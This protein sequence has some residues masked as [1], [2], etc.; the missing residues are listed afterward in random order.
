V[1]FAGLTW[2]HI[3]I[4]SCK[5]P[6][7]YKQPPLQLHSNVLDSN[8]QNTPDNHSQQNNLIVECLITGKHNPQF[9]QKLCRSGCAMFLSQQR[10][11][12]YQI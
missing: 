12:V 7:L 4:E 2:E 8:I 3:I 9:L 1:Y 10:N 6:A 11:T 5:Q